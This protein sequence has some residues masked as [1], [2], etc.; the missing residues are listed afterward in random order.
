MCCGNGSNLT[1]SGVAVSF[2]TIGAGRVAVNE[3]FN[4]ENDEEVL[5]KNLRAFPNP[6]SDIV[7]LVSSEPLEMA[8][9][10]VFNAIGQSVLKQELGTVSNESISVRSLPA[11]IY[12]LRLVANGFSQEIRVVKL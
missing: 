11:G 8:N 7:H 12:N 6:T 9:V 1:N 3:D 4:I 2:I 10:E 5:G